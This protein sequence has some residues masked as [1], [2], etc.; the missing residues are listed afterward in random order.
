MTGATS[1]DEEIMIKISEGRR[2]RV[3]GAAVGYVL[4]LAGF[5]G[6]LPAAAGNVATLVGLL[7]LTT[8]LTGWCPL[9]SLIHLD[10]AH[11]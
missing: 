4:L 1:A 8:A 3:T 10:T 7:A 2:D 9:Y 11:R 5:S 6:F